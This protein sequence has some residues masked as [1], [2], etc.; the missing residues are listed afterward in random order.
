MIDIDGQVTP[1]L[2][3]GVKKQRNANKI[4]QICEDPHE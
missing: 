3:Q 1:N 2:K 4:K